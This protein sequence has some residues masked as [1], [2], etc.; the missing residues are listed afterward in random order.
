MLTEIHAK[1]GSLCE[2]AREGKLRCPLLVRATSEDVITGEIV[3]ALRSMNPRYWLAD[4]LNRSLGAQRFHRQVY[5]RLRIEPWVNHLPYPKDL[6]PWTEGATQVDLE[7]HWENPPTT[8]FIEAKYQSKLSGAT[9]HGPGESQYPTDQLIRN[10]RVGLY[11]CGYFVRKHFFQPAPRDLAVL[12]MAPDSGNPLVAKY[13]Q[14][15]KILEFIPHSDQL[16]NLPHGPF[17]GEI[18]YNDLQAVLRRNLRF[19]ARSERAVV[20]ALDQY[21]VFKKGL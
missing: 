18:G 21:L 6:L 8:V 10:I 20:E 9:T 5:R 4:L 1:C 3:R 12:V 15:D 17:V 2:P 19:M 11:H 16:V 7:I 14:L 13:R